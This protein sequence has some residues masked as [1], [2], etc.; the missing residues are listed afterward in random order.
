MLAAIKAGL[1][2][3]AAHG[4]MPTIEVILLFGALI[5]GVTIAWAEL[6]RD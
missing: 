3:W 1:E 5:G 2:W 6:R 4:Q